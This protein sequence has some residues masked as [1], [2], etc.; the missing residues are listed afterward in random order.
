MFAPAFVDAQ[1]V[2]AGTFFK[3]LCGG[4]SALAALK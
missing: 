1:G 4:F 2:M 3:P